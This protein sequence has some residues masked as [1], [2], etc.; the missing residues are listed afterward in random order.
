M[1]FVWF[2]LGVLLLVVVMITL[3][4]I[5]RRGGSLGGTIG[6]SALVV[7][8]PFVGSIAYWAMRRP[9][10]AE[11]EHERLAQEDMRRARAQRPIGR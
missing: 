1:T 6:W 11:I 4:D 10:D 2:G 9:S 7:F 8:L 3:V 5:V